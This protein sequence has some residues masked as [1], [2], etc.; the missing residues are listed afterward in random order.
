MTR[1]CLRSMSVLISSS[2][3]YSLSPSSQ[4][5]QLPPLLWSNPAGSLGAP[6]DPTSSSELITYPSPTNQGTTQY[7]ILNVSAIASAKLNAFFSRASQNDYEDIIFLL[8]KYPQ[9]IYDCRAQL[10]QEHRQ[11]FIEQYAARGAG[12]GKLKATKHILGAA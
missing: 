2:K 7:R 9:E 6:L 4:N 1:H 11:A 10:K 12:Q 8:M 3:V 5:T